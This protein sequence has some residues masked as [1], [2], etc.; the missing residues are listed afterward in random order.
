MGVAF[1]L[2]DSVEARNIFKKTFEGNKETLKELDPEL[3]KSINGRNCIIEDAP[4]PS[5]IVWEN[6]NSDNRMWGLFRMLNNFLLNII[7]FLL[8]C[9]VLNPNM[10]RKKMYLTSLDC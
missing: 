3:Y 9:I 10:V 1:L 5:D 2:F 4:C 8:T 7:L 6:F